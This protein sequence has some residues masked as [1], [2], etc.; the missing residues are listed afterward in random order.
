MI[1]LISGTSRSGKTLIAEKMMKQCEI[2]YLSLDWLIMGFTNGIPEYG[3]HDKL[4]PNEIAEKFWPFLKAMLENML[5]SETSYIIEGEAILPE[6]IHEILKKHPNNIK[7][8]FV[9]Y[10]NMDVKEKVKDV[11]EYSN[12]KNDWLT[13]ESNDYVENHISNMVDYSKKIEKACKQY[14]VKY[15]D[16]SKNFSQVLDN[17]IK[18]LL[19]KE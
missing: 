12:G 9:G 7:I 2:P 16:T 17:V 19:E 13:N 10:S 15:F 5:W 6:L 1:Y 14:D 3:I 8:C 4:W 11:Y 18:Y